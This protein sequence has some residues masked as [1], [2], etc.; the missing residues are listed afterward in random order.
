MS[1]QSATDLTPYADR[2]PFPIRLTDGVRARKTNSGYVIETLGS[3][4]A[5]GR[6]GNFSVIDLGI[7]QVADVIAAGQLEL[8]P[9]QSGRVI[10]AV[11]FRRDGF[12]PTGS[13]PGGSL[14]F[15]SSPNTSFQSTKHYGWWNQEGG[16]LKDTFG[17][18]VNGDALSW[19]ADGTWGNSTDNVFHD[20]GPLLLVNDLAWIN[21]T[22]DKPRVWAANTEYAL[23]EYVIVGGYV[24][25][26]YTPGRSGGTEPTWDTDVGDTTNDGTIVWTNAMAANIAGAIH[27]VVE[28]EDVDAA[29][30]PRPTSMEFV[31]QPT[32]VVADAV[33]TPDVTVRILDQNGDPYLFQPRSIILTL[34]GAGTLGGFN[35]LPTDVT[36]GIATFTDLTVHEPGTYRLVARLNSWGVPYIRLVSDPFDVTTP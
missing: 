15:F 23:A 9:F 12:V 30:Y 20:N 21:T 14:M 31:Q 35:E 16:D 26:A 22:N 25:I 27:V 18:V 5:W 17:V 24:Q 10:R 1:E 3:D 8:L 6:V 33:I 7:I 11:Y 29:D 13:V 2:D 19:L 28:V 4:L 36:T 32:D 34:A